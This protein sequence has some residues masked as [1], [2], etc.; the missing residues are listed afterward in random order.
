MPDLRVVLRG[1]APRYEPPWRERRFEQHGAGQLRFALAALHERDGH[2]GDP[3]TL[4]GGDKQHLDEKRVA[5]GD[6]TIERHGGERLAPPASVAARAVTRAQPRNLPDVDVGEAA[7][8]QPPSRP[9][10]DRTAGYVP[11]SDHD[12]RMSGCGNQRLQMTR[13]VRKIRVHLADDVH[14]FVNAP[15]DAVDVRPSKTADAG[16]MHDV[17][18][19]GVRAREPVSHVTGPVRRL[20]VDDEYPNVGLPHQLLDEHR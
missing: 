16:A 14:R 19:T 7:E 11:G 1:S 9:V 4:S 20:I 13:I 8:Q 18:T 6:E 12:I 10:A 17:D 5:I 15:R 2:F 3:R